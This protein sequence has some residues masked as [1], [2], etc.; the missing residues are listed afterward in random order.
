MEY[1]NSPLM[2]KHFTNNTDCT[3]CPT[4]ATS[5]PIRKVKK[6]KAQLQIDY[7]TSSYSARN[8]YRRY[9]FHQGETKEHECA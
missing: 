1:I 8:G 4:A 7:I 6:K 3:K 5:I 2:L 9:E